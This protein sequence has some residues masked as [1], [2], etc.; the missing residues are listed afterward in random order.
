[1]D[2]SVTVSVTKITLVF[3]E[4]LN[5]WG[6]G[7]PMNTTKIEPPRI[8]MIPQYF[9]VFCLVNTDIPSVLFGEY[10]DLHVDISTVFCLVSKIDPQFC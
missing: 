1:M 9:P 2:A 10:R 7:L 8:L 4:D 6:R 3:V 5:S